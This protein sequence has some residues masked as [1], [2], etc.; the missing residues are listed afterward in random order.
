MF[1]FLQKRRL[2]VS[3]ER[4]AVLKIHQ[5]PSGGGTV[6]DWHPGG[7]ELVTAVAEEVLIVMDASALTSGAIVA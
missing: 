1:C 6:T 2:Q 3:S 7:Q 5:A 4:S